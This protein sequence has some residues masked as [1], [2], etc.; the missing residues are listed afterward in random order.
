MTD[1]VAVERAPLGPD[2]LFHLF[3][4]RNWLAIGIV[5]EARREF[6]S[7]PQEAKM[8]PEAADLRRKLFTRR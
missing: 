7:L 3:M 1:T 4:A 6:N 2:D 5:E 8:H